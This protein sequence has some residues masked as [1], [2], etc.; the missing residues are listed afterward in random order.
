[1]PTRLNDY[2]LINT[3]AMG[4]LYLGLEG[5]A[6]VL[7]LP[8]TNAIPLKDAE[9]LISIS[10][11]NALV[12]RDVATISAR[13]V[14]RHGQNVQFNHA[15]QMQRNHLLKQLAIRMKK[16]FADGVSAHI[17]RDVAAA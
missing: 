8:N 16:S 2:A 3:F 11:L 7:D 14:G 12:D 13:T 1:M 9:R 4:H 5:D 6:D 17:I 15:I 10:K